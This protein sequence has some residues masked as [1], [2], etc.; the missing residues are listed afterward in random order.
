MIV[1]IDGID[2]EV[3]GD[4][5]D[6]SY[7]MSPVYKGNVSQIDYMAKAKAEL[8]PGD[9]AALKTTPTGRAI[10]A[11]GWVLLGSIMDS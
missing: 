3:K 6:G 1:N 10:R 9:L 2:F 7:A 8:Q 11:I 4:Y 5:P